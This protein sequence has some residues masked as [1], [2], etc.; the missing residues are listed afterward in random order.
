M[1]NKYELEINDQSNMPFFYLP[2][3]EEAGLC[4]H[5]FSCRYA[6]S[7]SGKGAP[8][9]FGFKAGEEP[10]KVMSNRAA[11]LSRWGLGLEDFFYGEQVHES[12]VALVGQ[13]ELRS[14]LR[15]FQGVDALVTA[16]KGAVLGAFSADCLLVF[17]LAPD[18][19]AAGI[20][21]AGWRG[22]CKGIVQ[23]VVEIM[24]KKYGA[25]PHSIQAL[26]SPSIASCC[27]EV[28]EEVVDSCSRSLWS[29][30]MVM[31]LGIRPGHPYFDLQASNRNILQQAGLKAEHIFMNNYCTKCHDSLF[32]SYRG[33]GGKI[34]GSHMGIIYLK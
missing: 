1:Q 14:G 30:E 9:D 27:Y 31:H 2:L 28:G 26:F 6:K 5:G 7:E 25:N 10:V 18:I 13:E 12:E 16:E 34:A 24:I 8:L 22:T 23:H 11:F 29:K 4:G 33:A 21:H 15:A 20:A 32:Y 3:W 17:F 19:P